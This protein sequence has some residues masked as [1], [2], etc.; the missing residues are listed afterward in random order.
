MRDVIDQVTHYVSFLEQRERYLDYG[1]PLAWS[2]WKPKGSTNYDL[3]NLMRAR[4]EVSKSDHFTPTTYGAWKYNMYPVRDATRTYTIVQSSRWKLQREERRTIWFPSV[5]SHLYMG[6]GTTGGLAIPPGIRVRDRSE[7]GVLGELRNQKVNLGQTAGE[8]IV[9]ADQ[10]RQQVMSVYLAFK[11]ARRGSFYDVQKHLRRGWRVR[12]LS[13]LQGFKQATGLGP[14]NL[15]DFAGT[16]WLAWKFGWKPLLEDI[17]NMRS[18]ILQAMEK[19]D[20]FASAEHTTV[21][22]IPLTTGL[23]DVRYSGSASAGCTHKV[24]Y[25]VSNE[26]LSGLNQLGL[27]DPLSLT[28]ELTSLSF[29]IDWFVGVS[30]FLNGL[31]APLGLDFITGYRTEFTKSDFSFQPTGWAGSPGRVDSFAFERTRLTSFP[32]PSVVTNLGLNREQLLT[33]AVMF[34]ST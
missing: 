28:W 10:M 18:A 22:P 23:S 32:Q 2:A 4:S 16:S 29:V 20:S 6:I 8:L 1:V 19:D 13:R 26:T 25:R 30:D 24:W 9:G 3:R 33:M 31:S 17:T 11:A 14:T 12:R 15:V 21:L 27:I 7:N 5:T 34:R